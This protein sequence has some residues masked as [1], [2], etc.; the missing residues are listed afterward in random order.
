MSVLLLALS[1][2]QG[3]LD[4]G[5]LVVR[6][7]TVEV[8]REALRLTPTRMASGVGWTLAATARYDRS[9]PVVVFDPILEIA[10]DSAP[11][12]LEY[13]VADPREPLRILG[14][15]TRGRFGV[16]V[17][18]R[19]RERVREFLA[20]PPTVILDDSVF[21]LYVPVAWWSRRQPVTLTAIF[22]R[23]G[24]REELVAQDLGLEATTLNG[25][26]ASLRHVVA[27]GGAS[28]LVHI[29]LGRD[30]R[31]LKVEIPSRR[32]TAERAP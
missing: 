16:R 27:T 15:L 31:L 24:R 10:P 5:T 2:L 12:S 28:G 20:A 22:P 21:A 23:A 13:T 11:A 18:G 30:G 6:E 29:W 26:P 7:D 32:L 1:L 9:R 4:E 17:L 14:Q 8:A 3:P 25:D 19:H